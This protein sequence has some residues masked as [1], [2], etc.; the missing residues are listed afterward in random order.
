MQLFFYE[1]L[2]DFVT[3]GVA[4][5]NELFLDKSLCKLEHL[6]VYH[7]LVFLFCIFN[8]STHL[9]EH[10]PALPAVIELHALVRPAL[11]F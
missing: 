9:C 11:A 10:K 1:L 4:Q 6:V 5:Y 7:S 8:Q 3:L 2:W